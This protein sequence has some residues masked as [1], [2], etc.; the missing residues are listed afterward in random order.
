MASIVIRDIDQKV[1]NVINDL[2]KKQG[3][4]R[5]EYLRRKLKELALL[6]YEAERIDQY[7]NLVE[8][9]TNVI[10]NN[11]NV[12]NRIERSLNEK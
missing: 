10:E 1:L 7:K 3:L 9:V 5:E 12:L 11:T 2:A 8:Y 6:E 4:T